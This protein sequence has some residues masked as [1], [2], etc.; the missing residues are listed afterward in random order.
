[1][2]VSPG[3][4]PVLTLRHVTAHTADR[5]VLLDDVS[6]TAERGSFLAVVGPTGAGKTSLARALTGS[7]PLSEGAIHVDGTVAFVPQHDTLHAGLPLRRALGYAAALR[8]PAASDHE[9]DHA[10]DDTL[11]ELGLTEHASTTVRDL[12][13]GQRK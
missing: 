11:R 8:L 2:P 3:L 9:R 7:L 12:S 4:R 6:V 1:M 10:V 5:K 13:V